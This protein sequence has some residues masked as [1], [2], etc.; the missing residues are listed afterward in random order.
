MIFQRKAKCIFFCQ[1][2]VI[3]SMLAPQNDQTNGVKE[4]YFWPGIVLC[5]YI[6]VG[7]QFL[8]LQQ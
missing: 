8:I 3:C 7:W 6:L 2:A 4:F 1:T 5:N